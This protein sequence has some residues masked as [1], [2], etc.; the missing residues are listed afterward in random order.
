MT[1]MLSPVTHPDEGEAP[2]AGSCQAAGLAAREAVGGPDL[3]ARQAWREEQPPTDREMDCPGRR[4]RTVD[5]FRIL[6][7]EKLPEARGVAPGRGA[8]RV[9]RVGTLGGKGDLPTLCRSGD[10][11][12]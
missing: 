10:F 1:M 5:D 8:K 11:V 9:L 4:L 12:G 2:V 7:W 6:P 3:E